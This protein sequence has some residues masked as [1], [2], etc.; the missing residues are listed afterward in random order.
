MPYYDKTVMA[1]RK[2]YFESNILEWNG[3]EEKRMFGSPG[4]RAFGTLFC[5]LLTDGIV[6]TQLPEDDRTEA[7]NN[8]KCSIFVG[9]KGQ[10]IKN[11]LIFPYE[12]ESKLDTILPY[13]KKSYHSATL[14]TTNRD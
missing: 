3:T 4:Y 10:K 11:W 1:E 14:A 7:L 9:P 6:V 5:F 2:T 12:N 13:I 8:G